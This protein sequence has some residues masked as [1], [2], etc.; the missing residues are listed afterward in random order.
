MPE[1]RRSA[2]RR[3]KAPSWRT[4]LAVPALVV[5][6]ARI[7]T[8]G[9]LIEPTRSLETRQEATA[10]LLVT[11]EPPLQPVVLDG[12]PVGRTPLRLPAVAPGEHTVGVGGAEAGIVLR[13]GRRT[14]VSL[15]KG[16]LLVSSPA[17]RPPPPRS[18]AVQAPP[19]PR[20]RAPVETPP[21]PSETFS[22]ERFLTRTSPTFI[23]PTDDR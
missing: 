5:L 16:E 4:A 12:A 7:A 1:G 2:V 13:P 15:Y 3:R 9:E 19:A 23:A 21:P 18:P 14:I 20:A 22:W 11:S 17:E 10:A 8:G 6:S